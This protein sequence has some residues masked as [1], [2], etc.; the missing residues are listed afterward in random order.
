M[1]IADAGSKT[2]MSK[3]ESSKQVRMSNVQM[4]KRANGTF[5]LE[6]RTSKFGEQVIRVAKTVASNP[7]AAPILSQLVRAGTSIG[8]NYC[9]ATERGE[10]EGFSPQDRAVS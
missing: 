10:Q 8:A 1:T 7:V 2:R 4:S 5:D 9:E 6:E 3:L